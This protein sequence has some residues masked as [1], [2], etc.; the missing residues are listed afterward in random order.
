MTLTIHALSEA[1]P[2]QLKGKVSQEL[3]D[4]INGVISDSEVAEAYRDNLISYTS[5]LDKGKF[6]VVKYIDAVRYISFRLMG[7]T[8]IKSYIKT[9]PDKYTKFKQSGVS[10]ADIAKYVSAYNKSKLVNLIWEQSMIPFHV[11]N[12][13]SRQKALN[14]QLDLMQ[15]AMSEKV[16]CDAANSVLTHL[17]GPKEAKLEIEMTHK[18]GGV[19]DELKLAVQQFS[20]AQRQAIQAGSFSAKDIAHSKL[21]IDGSN[22]EVLND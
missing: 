5:V 11:F 3:I 7:E 2:K 13:D 16:R 14:V 17:Q 20:S 8:N 15:N 9:F 12:Q 19:I 10:D 22:G 6:T 1:M 4:K 21:L 18:D